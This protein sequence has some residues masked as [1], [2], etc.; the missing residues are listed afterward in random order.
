MSFLDTV[1]VSTNVISNVNTNAAT[2]TTTANTTNTTHTTHTTAQ[3]T[4]VIDDDWGIVYS[5][6]GVVFAAML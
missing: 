1:R 3:L 4:A 2:A 6:G 5:Q